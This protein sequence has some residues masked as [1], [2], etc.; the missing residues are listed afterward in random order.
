M[1]TITMLISAVLTFPF[2]WEGMARYLKESV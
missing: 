1:F 2:A